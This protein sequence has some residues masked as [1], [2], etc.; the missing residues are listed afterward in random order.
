MS[1]QN[2]GHFIPNTVEVK[3]VHGNLTQEVIQVTVDRLNIILKDHLDKVE[4]K[5][6]WIG[7]LGIFLTML[8][9][10]LT[11]EFKEKFI[12]IKSDVWYA[13]F[14]IG[15]IINFLY[16]LK[17]IFIAYNSPSV[18]DVIEIIKKGG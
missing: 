13:I 18:K 11:T 12:G 3:A 1:S 7:H 9:M 6:Q 15:I 4:K 14:I 8:V 17:S 16:L 10:F 5:N 2:G